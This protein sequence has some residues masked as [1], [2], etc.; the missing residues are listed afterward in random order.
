MA[1]SVLTAKGELSGLLQGT[2]LNQVSGISGIF[3]RA[4]RQLLLELDP[5]ET[6]RKT[7]FTIFDSVFDYGGINDL[8][9]NKITDI[10]PQSNRQLNDIFRQRYGQEFDILKEFTNQP[11]LTVQYDTA[12]KTLRI[13]YTRTDLSIQINDAS[14]PTSNGAWTAT[15][16]AAGIAQD[17]THTAQGTSSIRFNLNSGANPQTGYI[18]NSTQTAVD[19]TF[20]QG[21]SSLFVWVYVPVGADITS[22]DLRWGSSSANYYH[23]T[24]TTNQLGN[25]FQNGWNLLKFDWS[26]ATTV[27]APDYTKITYMRLSITNN[28]NQENGIYVSDFESRLPIFMD[29]WYYSKFLFRSVAGVFQETTTD[30]SDLINLDTDTYNV[31]LWLLAFLTMEQQKSGTVDVQY[32]EKQYKEALYQYKTMYK[33]RVQKVVTNYYRQNNP[34]WSRFLGK[35]F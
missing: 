8:K 12:A 18:E 6:E 34:R 32:F 28:G 4:A 13:E 15:A 20:H 11:M 26:S 10:R 30:D 14:S 21:I 23:K 9:G 17:T 5:Q 19:L 33:S 31:Y 3:N 7:Q 35:R 25:A 29:I 16:P 24:I 22:F 27:G 2:S 1:Y